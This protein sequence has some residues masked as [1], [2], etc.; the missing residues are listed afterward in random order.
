[1]SCVITLARRDAPND[2]HARVKVDGQAITS[3]LNGFVDVHR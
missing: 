1:M 3:P 2:A